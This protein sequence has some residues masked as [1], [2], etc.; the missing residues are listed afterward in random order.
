MEVRLIVGVDIV[1]VIFFV[2]LVEVDADGGGVFV[3]GGDFLVVLVPHAEEDLMVTVFGVDGGESFTGVE[4]DADLEF[5]LA[6]EDG[7]E[8]GFA[9]FEFLKF[10]DEHIG[11]EV[12]GEVFAVELCDEV[13]G[14]EVDVGREAG[15][16][17]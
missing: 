10:C 9:G 11:V 14:L 6:A 2:W 16:C 17:F 5:A 13:A 7:E 8:C 3:A 4:C 15:V 1:V 12:F